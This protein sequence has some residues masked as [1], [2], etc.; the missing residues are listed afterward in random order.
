VFCSKLAAYFHPPGQKEVT[1]LSQSLCFQI[2]RKP[3][4]NIAKKE[5]QYFIRL[6][7]LRNYSN[8]GDY[9]EDLRINL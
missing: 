1:E 9:M 6:I 3:H 7:M 4:T 8:S 5:L 2:L